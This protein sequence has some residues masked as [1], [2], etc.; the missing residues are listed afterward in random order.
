[1]ADKKISQLVEHINIENL[2]VLA[3][4]NSNETKKI[5][6]IGAGAVGSARRAHCPYDFLRLQRVHRWL[7]VG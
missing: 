3:I 2:D 5:A 1:M 4:V 6:V 7:H